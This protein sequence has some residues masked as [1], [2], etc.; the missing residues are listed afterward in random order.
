MFK[1]M[2][3]CMTALALIAGVAMKAEAADITVTVT[4]QNVA[5]SVSQGTWAIGPVVASSVSDLVGCTATN[6]GNVVEDFWIQVSNSS[7]GDWT[8]GGTAVED[9]FVMK[10]G[11]TVLTGTPATFETSVAIDDSKPVELHFTAPSSSTVDTEQT[12]TVTVSAS[13]S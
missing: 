5:V 8:A 6:D 3:I 7:S 2:L 11:T 9:V 12:I 4:L 1:K 13:A 10:E